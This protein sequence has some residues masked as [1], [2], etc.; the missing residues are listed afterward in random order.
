MNGSNT[1]LKI[2]T[3]KNPKHDYIHIL[4]SNNCDS[5]NCAIIGICNCK[6][7]NNQSKRKYNNFTTPYSLHKKSRNAT[8]SNDIPHKNYLKYSSINDE[9]NQNSN[10]QS[11]YNSLKKLEYYVNLGSS[12]FKKLL[13]FKTNFH[14]L[15]TYENYNRKSKTHSTTFFEDKGTYHRNVASSK[16]NVNTL[17]LRRIGSQINSGS[18]YNVLTTDNKFFQR[19]EGYGNNLKIYN[20]NNIKDMLNNN[21][22]IA[23]KKKRNFSED[24]IPKNTNELD[25]NKITIKN[26]KHIREK[27]ILNSLSSNRLSKKNK[28]NENN[29][30]NSIFSSEKKNYFVISNFNFFIEGSNDIYNL[31]FEK[32]DMIFKKNNLIKNLNKQ[33]QGFKKQINELTKKIDSFKQEINILKLK[34]NNVQHRLLE[35]SINNNIL[36]N[37]KRIQNL[38]KLKAESNFSIDDTMSKTNRQAMHKKCL[39]KKLNLKNDLS[40]SNDIQYLS[41]MRKIHE[42]SENSIYAIYPLTKAQSILCF[43]FENKNFILKDFADFGNFQENYLLA[44][45]HDSNGSI[46]LNHKSNYYIVTGENCDLFYVYN[47]KKKSIN[48]LSNLKNNHT[49]GNLTSFKD[50]IICLSGNHN[51]KVEL[52]SEIKNQWINLPELQIERSNF[53]TCVI[54]NKYIFCLFGYNLP[55]KQYLDSIEY[56]ENIN[57][58]NFMEWKYLKYKKENNLKLN[59]CGSLSFNYQDKKIIIA[60]GNNGKEGIVVDSFYQVLL[61]DDLNENFI[62]KTKRKL[63]DIDKNKSY[64][65]CKGYSMY[66]NDGKTFYMAFDNYYKAH[67]FEIN[68]MLHD[69]YNFN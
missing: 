65:F 51:K 31:L 62:E 26:S 9:L 29:K 69:I 44:N 39:S 50:N 40:I 66:S 61:S 30:A 35:T 43:D 24:L 1:H 10:I 21:E 33:I 11:L 19:N 15:P 32:D 37:K 67:I 41:K 56:L 22:V 58:D 27:N 20:T 55:T 46:F 25:N 63:K 7:D 14:T 60:G 12:H 4:H 64:F 34:L 59:V 5:C 18:K 2:L 53:T 13:N 16:Y 36:Y 54:K 47:P 17:K 38:E 28:L 68:N 57:N 48:K 6:C 49:N 23:N 45:S 52:Y 3:P 8:E 42:T